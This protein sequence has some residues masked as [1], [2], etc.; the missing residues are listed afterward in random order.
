M[1][2]KNKKLL[3]SLSLLTILS[4]GVAGCGINTSST[5]S[6]S[7]MEKKEENNGFKI[8]EENYEKASKWLKDNTYKNEFNHSRN[9]LLIRCF[10][11]EVP[12]IILTMFFDAEDS[13]DKDYPF[14]LEK[15]ELGMSITLEEALNKIAFKTDSDRFEVPI[16]YHDFFENNNMYGN[17]T[18]KITMEQY[19]SILDSKSLS[20]IGYNNDG[21]KVFELN[22]KDGKKK[23]D[24]LKE[25]IRVAEIFYSLKGTDW[26][27]D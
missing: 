20:L 9:S 18:K 10:K 7:S 14:K 1:K 8:T 3:V 5:T 12:Q 27:F 13:D 4:I 21:N 23:L 15:P 17:V 16:I 2:I 6:S 26:D 25:Q 11:G 22:D 19:K 24:E